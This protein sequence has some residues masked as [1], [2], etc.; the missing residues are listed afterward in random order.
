MAVL[1]I[2]N[3]N[4][5]YGQNPVLRDINLSVPEGEFFVLL[6][7]SGGGKSTLLRVLCGIE[8][9]DSGQVILAGRDITHMP[10]RERNIGMVFQ[11]YGLYPHMNAWENI[12]YGLEARGMPKSQIEQRIKVAAEKL[13]ITPLLQRIIVD[14]SGGE[15]QRVALAR[16][17]AKDADLY[18]FDEPLSNLDP[19]LRVQARRDIL[20]VH[21]EKHKP[22]LYVTHDQTE[23]LASGDRIGIVAR[24]RLQQIG[25]AEDLIQRPANMFVASF[26]GSPSMNLVD[27]TLAFD[28]D[29][30]VHTVTFAGRS[31]LR[32]PARWNDALKAY[33]KSKVVLGIPP[34][35][36][37][38][39]GG[40]DQQ[41]TSGYLDGEIENEEAL[42]GEVIVMLKIDETTS[43]AALFQSVE[44]PD[45]AIGGRL[46]VGIDGEQL[47]L[48]D[49]DTE[50]S[51][52]S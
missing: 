2:Q 30:G 24:G 32:L 10:P 13:G 4:K 12:A 34:T 9:A 27:S 29:Q 26:I 23:A 41:D 19:K 17:L 8:P 37:F 14:L 48:F 44:D 31:P 21:R 5:S 52:H 1:E 22:T 6:G 28:S 43:L 38:E 46:R 16:A 42:V 7:P 18:L 45:Y 36:F 35:A 11:D 33:N 25:T 15:Q 50:V 39:T 3:L 49:P 47:C 20:M 51:L 40:S